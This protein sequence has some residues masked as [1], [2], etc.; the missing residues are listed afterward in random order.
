HRQIRQLRK[1]S[2]HTIGGHPALGLT[3]ELAKRWMAGLDA[4]EQWATIGHRRLVPILRFL[5]PRQRDRCVSVIEQFAGSRA[6]EP[7]TVLDM[8]A[9][10]APLNRD[11][12]GR[13]L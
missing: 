7:H 2:I 4:V 9:Y 6:L 5:P 8:A 12:L 10:V 11:L 13:I 3:D 1:Q